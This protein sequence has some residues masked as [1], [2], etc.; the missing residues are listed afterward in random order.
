MSNC[1][2]H[3]FLL[4]D[5]VI[6]KPFR[7]FHERLINYFAHDLYELNFCEVVLNL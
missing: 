6:M 3:V 7:D 5:I 2:A 1:V 4:Y